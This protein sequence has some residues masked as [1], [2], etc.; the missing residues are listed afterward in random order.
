M[1]ECDCPPYDCAAR[2]AAYLAGDRSAGDELAR[3]FTGL[4]RAIVQRTLDTTNQAEIDDASQAIFLR[5]FSRLEAWEQRCPFCRW[6][7]VVAARRAIAYAR[8]SNEPLP[9]PLFD[10]VEPTGERDAETVAAIE[11]VVASWP[12][13]RRQLF[14]WL[15][16]GVDRDEMARRLGKSV[17]TIQYWLA[18]IRDELEECLPE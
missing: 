8:P 1:F 13:E 15:A 5:L 16:Q 6:L 18:G 7:A 3:K 4:V 14:E 12:P 9:L 17:R 10:V 2:V 11:Q